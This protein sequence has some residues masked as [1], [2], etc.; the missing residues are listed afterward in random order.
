MISIQ[1]PVTPHKARHLQNDKIY[2]YN[3]KSSG[4]LSQPF[5]QT[6]PCSL[7]EQHIHVYELTVMTY[8]TTQ[9]NKQDNIEPI[10][11]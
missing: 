11:T 3:S 10:I 7:A 6:Y 2:S 5:T 8:K 4:I 9:Y 1:L